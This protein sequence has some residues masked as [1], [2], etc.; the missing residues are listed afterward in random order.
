MKIDQS[1]KSITNCYK[2]MSTFGKILLFIGTLLIL[3]VFF[4]EMNSGL[5]KNQNQ[6]NIEGFEQNEQ[7]KH[8]KGND[9]YDDFYSNI[10]DHLVHNDTK[11]N[12]EL[13]TILKVTNP[14]QKSV[15][16][17][18]GSGT[19]HH[20]GK[21]SQKK[22]N[23]TGIDISPAMI[24]QALQNYPN[25]KFILGD[26]LDNQKF[27]LGTFTHILSLYFTIYFIQDKRLFFDNCMDWLIPGGFLVVH[28][29][30]PRKFDPILPPGNPLYI[31]SPQ[32]YAKQRITKTK[33]NFNK[34][35]YNSNFNYDESNK[36]ATFEEKFKF[37]DG[38]T[39]KQE[40]FL[41]MEDTEQIVAIAQQS[42]FTLHSKIDMIKCAYEYQY[43]Y[44][45]TKPA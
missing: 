33:V 13:T 18:I 27:P 35:V 12:F 24:K 23:V 16:L 31:V 10:Y 30:E 20:V 44:V 9:I 17:D 19:G 26:V 2:N 3:V 41:Y 43:L 38:K 6:N 8:L 42:G 39:R 34:F 5:Y 21:L 32:K 14:S 4:R 29:V 1:L 28:L 15:I 36:I 7:F 25:Q 45:F 22:Y 37:H 40:Q 11:N